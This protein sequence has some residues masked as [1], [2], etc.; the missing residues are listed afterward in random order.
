MNICLNNE[1]CIYLIPP[2][3]IFQM[4]QIKAIKPISKKF[5]A[6]V[7]ELLYLNNLLIL[8]QIQS[9]TVITPV[10]YASDEDLISEKMKALIV[11]DEPCF[12]KEKKPF[13]VLLSLH[14][15]KI[16]SAT[17]HL[18]IFSNSLGLSAET[19]EYLINLLNQEDEIFVL[20][21]TSDERIAA[22]GYNDLGKKALKPLLAG[23]ADYA[24]ILKKICSLDI[25]FYELNKQYKLENFD[26]L[27]L[28]YDVLSKKESKAYFTEEIHEKFNDV[29]IEYK[30]IL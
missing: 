25:L 1:T 16:M 10:F 19:I 12:F 30:E 26:D 8:D 21:K 14:N 27:K 17:N 28:L 11:D 13:N 5:S 2:Q 4:K 6:Y 20:S 15:Q 22:F 24:S 29:F 18:Y 23:N 9:S 3:P 7:N